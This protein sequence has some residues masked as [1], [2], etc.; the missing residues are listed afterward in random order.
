VNLVEVINELVEER[1]LDRSVLGSI[2]CDGIIA[3]FH[4]KYPDAELK[5]NYDPKTGDI[6]ILAKKIVTSSVEDELQHISLRKA[7]GIDSKVEL[8]DEIWA[9]FEGVIGRIEILK[10]KQVIANKI[11]NIEAA[12]IYDAFKDKEGTIV[13]GNVH[14]VERSGTVVKLQDYMAFLPKSLSLP[15]EKLTPG[16]P[17]KALLKEVLV[18]PRNENQLILDR[19]SSKFLSELFELEIPEV[20]E[21]V[22]EVKKIVRAPGYKS[23]VIV[24][25]SD[26]N[27]DPVG[28]CI[29]VGGARIKPILKEIDGEK[30]D[31][32][33]SNAS[34]EELVRSALKPAEVRRVE[35]EGGKAKV[36]LDDDQRSL[37]IGKMG[38]NISL[39]SKLVGLDIELI[40]NQRVDSKEDINIL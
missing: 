34:P 15:N 4:K 23:K 24:S 7:R 26:P 10:A 25:S 38:Q 27:I 16:Y 29:G 37:A 11:K 22:V 14:K 3:A 33:S 9:P 19:A 8:G 32:I 20:F 5:A 40:E 1:G 17:I 35:V 36:W 39:A 6:N 30:I 18:E 12:A 21:R 2:V 31:V 13:H 28:T